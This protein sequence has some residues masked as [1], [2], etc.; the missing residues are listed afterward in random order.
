MGGPKPLERVQKSLRSGGN[1]RK[2]NRNGI[3]D[4]VGCQKWQ[5]LHDESSRHPV[6][7]GLYDLIG[8]HLGNAEIFP[9]HRGFT[10]FIS[11]GHVPY[12]VNI[13]AVRNSTC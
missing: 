5:F 4:V 12:A 6:R 1:L 11:T 10:Y 2:H 7:F 9:S 3:C 13:A 8:G